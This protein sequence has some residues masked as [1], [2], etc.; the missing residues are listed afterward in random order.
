MLEDD[1]SEEVQRPAFE[2]IEA[3]HE[4]TI[5]E[6]KVISPQSTTLRRLVK[7]PMLMHITSSALLSGMSVALFKF[8]GEIIQSASGSGYIVLLALT[9]LSISTL[10]MHMIANAM[11]YY[12]Q[13][14]V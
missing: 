12:D 13:I 3:L 11:K 5:E 14:E 1:C 8:F 2:I 10:Q 7:C 9:A 6:V 4:L